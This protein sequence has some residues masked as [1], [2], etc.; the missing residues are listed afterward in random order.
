MNTIA[1][2]M[3]LCLMLTGA[4]GVWAQ[5]E[6]PPAPVEVEAVRQGVLSQPLVYQGTVFFDRT[7]RVTSEV[8]GRVEEVQVREGQRVNRGDTLVRLGS[9]ILGQR[10]L[11][12]RAQADELRVQIER[13]RQNF[14]R[15]EN[16]FRQN[17]SSQ[18]AYDDAH[19]ALEELKFRLVAQEHN[20]RALELEL[21]HKRILAPFD[22]V[23]LQ[24]LA[25]A[26][27]WVTP[28]APV[29]NLAA[30]G[31]MQVIVNVSQADVDVIQVGKPVQIRVQE[32]LHAGVVDAVIPQADTATRTFPVKVRVE[33][34]GQLMEG[35]RAQVMFAGNDQIDVLLVSRDSVI[36]RFGQDVL[37]VV[38]DGKAEMKPVEI[39]AYDQ[40]QVGVRVAGLQ[41]GHLVVV[42]GNERISPQ[43]AVQIIGATT[44]V[45]DN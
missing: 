11:A 26:G 25:E 13:A 45:K 27:E 42:K 3:V 5:Q 22:G 18:Q 34:S 12:A 36:R 17:L 9:D 7:A 1:R 33:H 28:G 44:S 32:K 19:Y 14:K 2:L 23:V 39:I 30:H 15:A 6:R 8:S 20:L 21:A 38:V 41:E 24:R 35:M 43:Q 16:L 31:S 40:L 37:F 10:L 29:V 4:E